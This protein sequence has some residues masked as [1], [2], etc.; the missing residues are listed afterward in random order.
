MRSLAREI[1]LKYLFAELFN[2]SDE[3]L[4][5]V[6]I[7]NS[8][9]NKADTEFAEKLKELVFSEFDYYSDKIEE[10][11]IG[12][13][14]DRIRPA[15]KCALMIGMAELKNCLETP[16][17]VVIDEAVKLSFKYSTE[18]STDYV[19]GILATFAREVRNG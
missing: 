15:D 9:L 19:N 12:F 6:L 10:L 8:E 7:K 5:A 4:F 13:K 2:P 16:V 17:P 14:A 1:V 11:S 18:K 3:E